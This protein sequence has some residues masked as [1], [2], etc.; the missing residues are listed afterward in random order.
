M[1]QGW[2]QQN[3]GV[4]GIAWCARRP[5]PHEQRLCPKQQRRD[6]QR[7]V[8]GAVEVVEVGEAFRRTRQHGGFTKQPSGLAEEFPDHGAGDVGSHGR[9]TSVF[10]ADSRV[11]S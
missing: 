8:D 6:F 4:T 1:A 9:T 2:R 5:P 3:G 11:E 7:L 10:A